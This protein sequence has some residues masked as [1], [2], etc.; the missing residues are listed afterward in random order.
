MLLLS[1]G[2]KQNEPGVRLAIRN[3]RLELHCA[4]GRR[5]APMSQGSR[6][7]ERADHAVQVPPEQRFP[8]APPAHTKIPI[9]SV[10]AAG[11]LALMMALMFVSVWDD[12]PTSDDNVA[13]ISGYSY[14]RKQEYRL[15]PQNPPLIKDLAAV[16][17]LLMSIREP[18]DRPGWGAEDDPDVLGREFL[19]HS[20]NDPDAILRAARAPM[21]L[22]AVA[23]GGLLFLWTRKEFGGPAA[24]PALFLYVFSPT[25]LA[26]GR[27]VATDLGATAGFFLTVAAFLRLLRNPTRRNLALAGL[28]MGFAFLT[29]FSTVALIPITLVLAT[30]WALLA[31]QAGN[32]FSALLR[33]LA[34]TAAMIAIAYL[35]VYAVYLHHIWN[36]APELQVASV[37]MHRRL[38]GLSGAAF[39]IVRWASDK[40]VL[41]PLAEYFLGLLVALKASGWGQPLFFLGEVHPTG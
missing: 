37:E 26:H 2:V 14:L 11:L 8:P 7:G 40:P 41:R 31:E 10:A 13:L 5:S 36:Y 30:A 39:D 16:P 24:P 3:D 33:T 15:E 12:T 22:F 19:Y 32:P 6:M 17:L 23:F 35:V 4:N 28:A 20:G 18:W 21:I 38:Y 9:H 29:K 1:A 25:F 27:L 34:Q